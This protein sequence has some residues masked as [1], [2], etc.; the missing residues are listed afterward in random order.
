MFYYSRHVVCTRS[1]ARFIDP[2]Q[3]VIY[4]VPVCVL[5]HLFSNVE[6]YYVRT[7]YG[8]MESSQFCLK[9]DERVNV[10]WQ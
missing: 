5:R 7:G 2:D 8:V 1:I 3:E 6:F 4:H 10:K 9:P